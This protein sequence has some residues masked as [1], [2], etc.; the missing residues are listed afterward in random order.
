VGIGRTY[1]TLGNFARRLHNI[2]NMPVREFTDDSGREWRAWAVLP[3]AIHPATKAEDYLA[4]CYITGW[5]VFETVAQDEKRRLCPWPINWMELSDQQMREL[6]AKAAVVP[7][8]RLRSQRQSGG[9]AVQPS[10]TADSP[11]GAPPDITDLQVVRI[12]RYPG[13]RYWTVN[14]VRFPERGGLPVLRFTAGSRFLELGRW[15]KD[16]ADLPEETLIE[17]LRKAGARKESV[18]ARPGTPRRRWDDAR[19]GH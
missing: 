13:G 8:D 15:P 6:L 12:F 14:V 1:D 16:W 9:L 5:I 11:A 19:P 2:T 17:L 4:D 18:S 3:E 10:G 7:A